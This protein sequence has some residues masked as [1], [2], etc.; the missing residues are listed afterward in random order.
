MRIDSRMVWQQSVNSQGIRNITMEKWLFGGNWS[1]MI[2]PIISNFCKVCYW[3]IGKSVGAE[4]GN[5]TPMRFPPP[6]FETGMSTSSITSAYWYYWIKWKT[7]TNRNAN[8]LSR[9]S[10]KKLSFIPLTPH[11]Y[12]HI[13]SHNKVGFHQ[14]TG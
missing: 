10:T 5:R 14:F 6:V 7:H 1:V 4:R 2:N 12:S 3:I 9:G 11:L 8:L 13:Y